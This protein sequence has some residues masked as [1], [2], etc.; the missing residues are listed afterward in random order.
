MHAVEDRRLLVVRLAVL[1]LK[2]FGLVEKLMMKAESTLVLGISWKIGRSHIGRYEWWM[3]GS[4]GNWWMW[5]VG[6]QR[7]L[8]EQ[9]EQ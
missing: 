8:P 4:A 6:D 9:Y 7:L 1:V 2:D 5:L 3:M